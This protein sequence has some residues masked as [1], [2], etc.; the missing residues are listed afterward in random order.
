MTTRTAA[1]RQRTEAMRKGR[2]A[3]SARRRQRV[4][5]AL[6]KAATDG[7][8]TGVSAIARAAAVDRSF[9]YR[10]RDLLSKIH[11]L[12]ASPPAAGERAGPAVTRASLQAD[13]IAA[14]ERALRLI[15]RVRQLERRLSDVL[16]EQA[17]RESGLG[18]PADI[19]ALNQKIT[20]LEQQ[21]IDLQLQLEQRDEDL[22]AARAANRELMAQ[23]NHA[24]R[25][26]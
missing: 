10:H 7:A 9:L 15:T 14:H 16:G 12:E 22:T 2:Q 3:D 4:I 11:A 5:A 25:R 21:A 26:G 23:L 17:W 24:M 19:G 18:T 13:L 6:D 8:E 20:Q 1:A